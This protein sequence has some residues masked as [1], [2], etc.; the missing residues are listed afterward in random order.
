MKRKDNRWEQWIVLA[1]II[2][3]LVII[4]ALVRGLWRQIDRLQE[5][6]AAEAELTPLV[7]HAEERNTQLREELEHI[8]A[9]D[10]IEEWARVDGGMARPGEVRLVV[11]LPEEAP[12]SSSEAQ[13]ASSSWT[14]FWQDLW[15]QLFGSE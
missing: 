7:A 15:Q 4:G 11:P 6:R 3:T 9:P 8:D 10:Y 5:L 13:P 1:T 14:S 12:E 2:V